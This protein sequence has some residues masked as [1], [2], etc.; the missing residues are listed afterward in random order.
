MKLLDQVDSPQDLK[1][2]SVD[3]LPQLSNEI[4]DF[5]IDSISKTGGHLS[6]NLGAVELSIALHYTM[7]TPKDILVWDVGHQ[8]YVH[9]I[10]TG[11]KNQFPTL[12][13]YEGISGFLRREESVY[14][15]F[16]AGH[17]GT[18]ISA[19]LGFAKA[20]DM[21]EKDHRVVAIIGDGS[22]TAGMAF[23]ALNN[24]GELNSNILVI[25]NDNKWSIAPNVGFIPKYLNKIISTPIYNRFRQDVQQLIG[26]IP[27]VGPKALNLAK[28]IEEGLKNL[29]V[30]DMLF[31]EMGFRYFGPIDGHDVKELVKELN[32]IKDIKGPILLHAITQKGK[33]Y[34]P[35]EEDPWKSH[36]QVPFDKVT[37]QPLKKSTVPSYTSIFADTLIELAK[38]NPKIVA[39]TA[40]MPDGT[41]LMKFQKAHPARYFDVGIAEQ[42]AVTFA[43][44]LAASGYHPVAA[45]Y[46]T[47]LQRAYDQVIHDVCIQNLPVV[48]AMD[49]GGVVGGDGPTH[50]G[51]FDIA[52]LRTVPNT[53]IMA[54]KDGV[55]LQQMLAT[56][57]TINGPS[58]I[59]YPRGT[60]PAFEFNPNPTP[61]EVGKAEWV[62][63]GE[64]VAILAL[65]TRVN[66]AILAASDLQSDEIFPIVVNPRF[67]KPLDKEFFLSLFRKVKKVVIVEDHALIGG[68][69]SAILE[70]LETEGFSQ[71]KVKRLGF[72][73]KFIEH[74]DQAIMYQKYGIDRKAIKEAVQEL[75]EA[76]PSVRLP[77]KTAV[78]DF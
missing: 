6:S 75:L 17:A 24:A 57:F 12:K 7:N 20:R 45:I 26:K 39:I 15:T 31:E 34:K 71:I 8:G 11:R 52:Y 18:S 66:E 69:G 49:R 32:N 21:A 5:L 3:Q 51:L 4:R 59:R 29:I 58:A 22:M 36:G 30:P 53:V 76:K 67:V 55:E 48:F 56:A 54:P 50:Q 13:K 63:E 74:G 1:K 61:L 16:G 23:E 62:C 9:K 2:L 65:G 40:A 68:F 43:A 70:F 14:D 37:A 64:D 47:F 44:G 27:S 28:K 25:L 46:S 73:D 10:L 19:A 41:G 78:V 35:A 60:A 38:K 42:H 72:P 77:N 33:G